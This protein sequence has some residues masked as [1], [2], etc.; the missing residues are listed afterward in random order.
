MYRRTDRDSQQA[1]VSI[2]EALDQSAADLRAGRVEDARDFADTLQS[3]LDE[4]RKHKVA[5]RDC[6]GL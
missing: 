3:R 1:A 2:A 5:A 4:H 6:S